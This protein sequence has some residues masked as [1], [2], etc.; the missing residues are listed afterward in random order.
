MPTDDLSRVGIPHT[1]HQIFIGGPVPPRYERY[2]ETWRRHHPDWSY[3][4][5]DES[6]AHAL[7]A[8]HYPAYL[9]M[10][11]GYRHRIQRIDAVRYF[12]LHRHGG[13]YLDMDIE[14]LRPIDELVAGRQL[15]FTLQMG[16]YS[17]GVMGSVAAHPFWPR[18]FECLRARQRRF[19]WRA[20]LSSKL[21]MPM[22]VGY[23]TGPILLGDCLRASGYESDPAVQI[24]PTAAFE[25]HAP[26]EDVVMIPGA[27]VDLSQSYAVHHMAMH[28]LPRHHKVLFAIFEVFAKV[29]WRRRAVKNANRPS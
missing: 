18:V 14:C 23:S 19:A 26:R 9:A 7:I 29:Y 5:W 17:N 12:L 27:P 15:L 22:H 6:R 16:G 4:L 13:V 3:E 1:I 10:Y 25:P 24:C 28:W 11:E 2:A 20:P 8:E 21:T